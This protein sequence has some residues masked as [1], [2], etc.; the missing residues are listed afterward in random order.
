MT[1]TPSLLGVD[2]DAAAQLPDGLDHHRAKR[3]RALRELERAEQAG[4]GDVVEL[5]WWE[6]GLI[7]LVLAPEEGTSPYGGRGYDEYVAHYRLRPETVD[8]ARARAG[9][10]GDIILKLHY[11]EYVLLRSEPRGRAWIDLQRALL[12]A[13]RE[14][15][16]GCRAGAKNDREGFA[17]GVYIDRALTGIERLFLR[18]GVVRGREAAEWAEWLVQLA[19]DSRDFPSEREESSWLRHR[20][21]AD[22]LGRLAFLPQD[23]ASGTLRARALD[24][25]D[26]AAAYYASVPL[27]EQF[28]QRVAERNAQLRKH[29]GET[30]THERMTRHIFDAILRRAE[31]HAATGP[32]GGLLTSHF[33]RE[34]RRIAEEHRQYFTAEEIA[35]LQVAEQAAINQAISGGEFKETRMSIEMPQEALDLTRETPEAT[36]EALVSHAAASVPNRDE[37]VRSVGAAHATA[38]LQAMIP[39]SVIG[40]GKVVGESM[41]EEGNLELDVERFASLYA[42]LAGEAVAFTVSSAARAVGLTADHLIRPLQD[43]DL[44]EG[45]V[46]ILRRGCE[47]FVA[48]DY[49]S[50]THVFL[51]HVEDVLRQQLRARGVDTTEFRRDAASGMSRTDDATLG[52]LMRKA[53]PDGRTVREYLGPNLWDHLDS[54]LNSQTGLNLRND[55]AHGLARP[56]HCTSEIAG[57]ALSLLYLL[58]ESHGDTVE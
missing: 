58:A 37:I 29:W 11:L 33:F 48:G 40:P 19:D 26:Q 18:P 30:D 24:M 12:M 10:T 15:V 13:W 36:V 25:M 50:A 32:G 47:R 17:V 4:E 46:E 31:F 55:F 5:M 22:F 42:R 53:L 44:D 41:S 38:P 20:W 8:Y 27:R 6:L 23:S 39:R 56:E 2:Y 45:T 9:E 34:A 3:S 28:E 14:Y 21:V 49:F 43:V 51:P 52:A 7:D 35:R 57:I 16:N 54:T 1:R